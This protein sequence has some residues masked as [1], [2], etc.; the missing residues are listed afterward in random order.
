MPCPM[1]DT[2]PQVDTIHQQVEYLR[3]KAEQANTQFAQA[4]ERFA[5]E[6]D[7][8]RAIMARLKELG[9]RT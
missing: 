5:T 1:S 6:L 3:R 2:K 8:I 4:E 9:L 7:H